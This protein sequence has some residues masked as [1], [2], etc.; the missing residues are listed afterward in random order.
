MRPPV[1]ARQA[2]VAYAAARDFV[3]WLRY[4][5]PEEAEFRQLLSQL[6]N[7]RGFD[8]AI[9]DA[10]GEPLASLDKHWR[11]GLTGRSMSPLRAT[12]VSLPSIRPT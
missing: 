5:H 7:G 3:T 1:D 4:H 11:S 10:Y 2:S 9:E 8:Q 6:H 12:R